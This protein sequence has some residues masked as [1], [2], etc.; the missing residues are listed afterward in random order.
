MTDEIR[1][2]E[3][4]RLRIAADTE[5]F[6]CSGGCVEKCDASQNKGNIRLKMNKKDGRRMYEEGKK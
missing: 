5:K 3:R 4:N 6:L 1:E 2:N